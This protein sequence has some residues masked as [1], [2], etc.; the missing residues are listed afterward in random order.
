[1]CACVVRHLWDSRNN[2]GQ[3]S[4]IDVVCSIHQT[5]SGQSVSL[6]VCL[7]TR[8]IVWLCASHTV[9]CSGRCQYVMASPFGSQQDYFFWF[10]AWSHPRLLWKSTE[11]AV[12]VHHF[13][14]VNNEI[15]HTMS[16]FFSPHARLIKVSIPSGI[17][18]VE[19][20]IPHWSHI[21]PWGCNAPWFICWFWCSINHLLT[22]LIKSRPIS[23]PLS[24]L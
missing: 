18:S 20:C 15:L 5:H 3:T 9:A 19:S 10:C 11:S 2:V 14:T 1:M 21:S 16:I 22:Y 24:R 7:S 6:S 12:K 8:C 4:H 17:P 23:F 13:K